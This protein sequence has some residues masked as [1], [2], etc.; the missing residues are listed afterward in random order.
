MS[1]TLLE[2]KD[3]SVSYGDMQV[4]YDI[5]LTVNEG[6]LVSILGPNGAGKT[7]LIKTISGLLKPR[8]GR[9]IFNS[10]D[11][12]EY[13]PHLRNELG[14]SMVPEG[15]RIFPNLTVKE[16]LLL[17]AYNR[18]A[19]Q[20]IKESL[21]KVYKMFPILK[22]REMQVA[23]TLSGGESQM[24]AIGRALMSSPK[25]LLLDEP[26][27]GLAPLV[28]DEVFNTVKKLKE[29]GVT[30]LL[31]EQHTTHALELS[32]YVYIL[33]NGRIVLSGNSHEIKENEHV[34]EYYLGI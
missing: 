16:N 24:L 5:S 31:V 25:M 18:R 28:V 8:S 20:N 27:L 6:N 17:G 21:E 1:K 32:D 29:S 19:R 22:E 4:L 11:I 26:S 23:K 2:V 7:T 10:I 34:K 13:P 33:E 15:R 9:I 3:I 12:T 30:V 14:I